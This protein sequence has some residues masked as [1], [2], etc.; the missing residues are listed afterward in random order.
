MSL[1]MD[2]ICGFVCEQSNTSQP[3]SIHWKLKNSAIILNKW[4]ANSVATPMIKQMTSFSPFFVS[5]LDGS[6]VYVKY[7]WEGGSVSGCSDNDNCPHCRAFKLVQ[8]NSW[9]AFPQ[10]TPDLTSISST[11]QART[12]FGQTPQD[13]LS[14]RSIK[15][16]WCWDT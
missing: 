16:K 3:P 12:E 14:W 6:C 7:E 4:Q 9:S 1:T 8:A 2:R 13:L 10:F 11:S 5:K 15:W